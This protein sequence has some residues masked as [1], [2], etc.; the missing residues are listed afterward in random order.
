[1]DETVDLDALSANVV[2]SALALQLYVKCQGSQMNPQQYF[3]LTP[4]EQLNTA[5]D[6]A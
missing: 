3:E 1:M 4:W 5:D 6:A 2:P